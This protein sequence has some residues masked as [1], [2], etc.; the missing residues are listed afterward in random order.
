[1]VL[2]LVSEKSFGIGIKHFY[3]WNYILKL[4]III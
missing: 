3:S 4:E 1:M 2:F